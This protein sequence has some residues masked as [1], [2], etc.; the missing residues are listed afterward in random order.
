M[1]GR[2]TIKLYL[3]NGYYHIYNRGVEKRLIFQDDQDYGVFL[4][5]LKRYLLKRDENEL[6]QNY[7]YKDLSAD[8]K[9]I[10][11]CLMPNHFHLL[12]Q[13]TS[14]HGITDI[15]KC[16]CTNYSVYFNRRNDRVGRLFQGIYKAVLVQNDSYLLH[17]S[18]YIHLNPHVISEPDNYPYSSYK[19]Y[20]GNA[21]KWLDKKPV[22]DLFTGISEYQKF[23][24]NSE[25]NSAD[26]LGDMV[27]EVD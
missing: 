8:V 1:P 27:I 4:S 16:L 21:P 3:D 7:N 12:V 6:I 15:M 23:M 25:I 20:L 24:H 26:I 19:Y 9:L 13:Q 11:Y 14:K 10:S 18:R 2:N 5:Y 17:L 22:S